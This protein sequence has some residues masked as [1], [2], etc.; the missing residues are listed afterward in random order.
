MNIILDKPTT[1]EGLIKISLQESD[2]LPK[3][4]EKI[5]DY[6]KK[7]S[8]KGFRAGKVPFGVIRKMF[9]KSILVEEINHLISHAVTDYIKENK[10]RVLGDPM[11]NEE[12][13]RLI[14]WDA[15]K[16]FE[17]EFQ[18]GLVNDFSVDV[19]S[20]VKMTKYV[21]SVDSKVL[22]E[23]LADVQQR[24]GEVSYPEESAAGDNLSG[25]LTRA[26]GSMQ[27]TYI[28][29][30]KISK[31][32]Q[33]KFIGVRKEDQITFDPMKT[34]SESV[35]R[36]QVLGLTEE[37]ADAQKGV[38]TLKVTNIT[39]VSPAQVNQELFD[40]VFGKEVVTS[41]E[42]FMEKIKATI[43]ENYDRET[44]HLLDHEIQHHLVD[45]T[46]ITMPETFLKQ[47]LKNSSKGEVTD[48]ILEKE[49]KSYAESLKWD[50][51]K[52][53]IAED[54]SVNV[55][56]TEVREKAK[57]M[58]AEQFGG[59]AI[60]A[61]LGDKMD[62]IAD[63][64]LSGQDGKGQNFMRIYNQLRQEKIIGAIKEKITIAEKN[65]TLEEFKKLVEKHNH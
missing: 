20:K 50:L 40:K 53:K 41:E 19:T 18:I 31:K 54:L 17:F 37:L 16:D 9:G 47:W 59:A 39:R 46:N 65:V 25:E 43:S 44:T 8:I 49:F 15:Q 5:K 35:V 60:A 55:D 7:A 48:E 6:A 11:P 12:K 34:F 63:N 30:D 2:Y 22:N 26:D 64:Y 45:H 56:G 57:Q 28:P 61:Q 27:N 4:D 14:D 23:T 51:I 36:A 32:E 29:F 1:T 3:V 21:I 42:A 58:I 33:D 62:S 24:F 38:V 10:L 52:N 13:A